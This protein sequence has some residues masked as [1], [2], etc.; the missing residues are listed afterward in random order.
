MLKQSSPGNA[1]PPRLRPPYGDPPSIGYSPSD[2]CT[3][4]EWNKR[5]FSNWKIYDIPVSEELGV[6]T[7]VDAFAN[8][9]LA[10]QRNLCHLL[11]LYAVLLLEHL[12]RL[13]HHGY[14]FVARASRLK[15]MCISGN[16]G[17]TAVGELTSPSTVRMTAPVQQRMTT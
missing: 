12:Q 9:S 5:N 2:C 11:Q 3:I 8:R 1:L 17:P 13:T 6:Y 4:Y 15:T 10:F 7:P 16:Y 14:Q